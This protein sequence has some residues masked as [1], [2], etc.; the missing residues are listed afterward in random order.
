MGGEWGA[1]REKGSR[2]VDET[3]GACRLLS[4]KNWETAKEVKPC[5]CRLAGHF[6]PILPSVRKGSAAGSPVWEQGGHPRGQV[7]SARLPSSSMHRSANEM[8][9]LLCLRDT[10]ISSPD[11]FRG[12]SRG[13]S[14]DRGRQ[15]LGA[16][17]T[18][19]CGPHR[20]QQP[21]QP[22][23]ICPVLLVDTVLE[24]LELP[25]FQGKLKRWIFV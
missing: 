7:A 16:V 20:R 21:P 19:Q 4:K 15:R 2:E 14:R 11:A 8:Y 23:P 10:D 6:G 12:P 1:A 24:S 17:A 13:R 9:P 5:S 22:L 18:G 25:I 3:T